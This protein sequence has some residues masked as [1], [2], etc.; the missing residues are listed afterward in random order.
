MF[1][2]ESITSFFGWCTVINGIFLVLTTLTLII[3]KDW[4]SN[5]HQKMFGI[6]KQTLTTVYFKYL[7]NYKIAIL[8]FN[9]VPYIALRMIQ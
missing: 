6:D 8:I 4:I 1:T 3:A 2:M 5:I 9:L 7:S